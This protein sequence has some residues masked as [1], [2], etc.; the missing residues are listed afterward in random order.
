MRNK[1]WIATIILLMSTNIYA[2]DASNVQQG[3]ADYDWQTCLNTKSSDCI[4]NCATSE[5]LTCQ[6]QCNNM[7][8]DKCQ[9]EGLSPPSPAQ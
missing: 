7:A 2:D 9:A 4:N 5:D 1:T 3:A 8:N 6:D